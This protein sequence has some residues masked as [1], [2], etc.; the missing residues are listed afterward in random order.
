M[1]EYVIVI[2]KKHRKANKTNER[3]E[4]FLKVLWHNII[5]LDDKIYCTARSYDK[6]WSK[7]FTSYIRVSIPQCLELLSITCWCYIRR[8]QNSK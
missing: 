5:S 4:T 7:V 8:I 2:Y 1:K 3:K 6:S